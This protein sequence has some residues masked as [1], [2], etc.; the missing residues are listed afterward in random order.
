MQFHT[1]ESSIYGRMY[2]QFIVAVRDADA[3]LPVEEIEAVRAYFE[4]FSSRKG[5][6]VLAF[7]YRPDHLHALIQV[8]HDVA[9]CPFILAARSDI[10]RFI[11]RRRPTE[12]TVR[13]QREIVI[14]SYSHSHLPAVREFILGQ[15]DYHQRHSFREEMEYILERTQAEADEKPFDYIL[16]EGNARMEECF[17]TAIQ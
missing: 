12:P 7:S 17:P 15:D 3:L 1:M 6:G 11:R 5:V 8:P 14:L 9:L 2:V 4:R 13:W 16:H 10:S